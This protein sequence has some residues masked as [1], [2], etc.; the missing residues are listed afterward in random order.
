MT[1]QRKPLG[2]TG[3]DVSV[4]CLG[5]MT[6]GEQ[7]SEAEAFEQL[8]YA[9]DRGINFIDTAELYPVP[10]RPET[11]GLTE[12]YLGNWL[13]TRGNRNELVIASKVTGRGEANTGVGHIRGGPRLDGDHIRR[14]VEATLARLQTDYIDLYQIHWP[15]RSTNFFGQLGYR[16][17]DD[18]GIA[19]EDTLNALEELVDWGMVRH[20]GISNETPWGLM[21]YLRLADAHDLPVIQSIQNPYNLLN[22]SF[23]VGLAEM[24]LREQIAVL[25]YSPLAFGMLT[26][27]YLGGMRPADARL[28]LFSRFSRYTNHESVAA[29]EAYQALAKAHG[30][31]LTQMALAFLRQQPWTT[32]T[33]IGATSIDQLRENIDSADLV[34]SE[35]V[36]REIDAVHK[37][38]T[39]PAP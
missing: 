18:D 4:L 5:T 8:D 13:A 37:R 23:E 27:K 26:G 1:L 19:I 14:A 11:Q 34:L 30:L 2:K 10:P 3:L 22:R 32:S 12:A 15:E 17:G 20:I 28:T 16:H 39:I 29:T 35:E 24:C 38:Y 7:N 9:T 33:I 25:P 21:K 6:W 31:S 36:L